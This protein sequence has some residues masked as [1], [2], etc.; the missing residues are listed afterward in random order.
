MSTD[1]GPAGSPGLLGKLTS[2]LMELRRCR[3]RDGCRRDCAH[4]RTS[5][6][7]LPWATEGYGGWGGHEHHGTD[8]GTEQTPVVF[9]HGNQRDACDWDVHAEFFRNRSYGGDDLWAITFGSGSPSHDEMADQLDAFVARVRE[10]TGASS[11]A[12]VSHSLGVTG[13]RYWLHREDR[14]DWVDTFVGLAGANHG[15]VLNSMAV[16]AGLTTGTYK[17]SRFLRKD[18]H[19]LSEHPLADLNAEET[20][21]D[22][23]YYTLRGTDDPLF[24]NCLDSPA[25]EGAENVAITADHDGVRASLPAIE[26]VFEWCSGQK[27]YNFRALLG[28]E[29]DDGDEPARP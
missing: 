25:L 12:V 29:S 14:Y 27:P 16:R 20:P 19:R 2:N 1:R 11:V 13:T 22:V 10:Y 5:D 26:H 4:D 18:Y 9:V 23:D 7:R 21:G 3:R 17:M 15:T 6:A 24:W 28:S 8:P